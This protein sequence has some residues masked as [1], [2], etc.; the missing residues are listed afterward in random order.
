MQRYL[1]LLR[2]HP[3]FTRLWFAQI[4]SLAGDW[5][6]TVALSAL[7]IKYS[8]PE[9]QGLAI[10]LFFLSRAV[11]PMLLSP[12][13]GVLVDRFN[14]RWLMIGSNLLRFVV[15][16]G[17][18][19]V[20]A[21]PELL[22]AVYVLTIIQF[23]LTTVFEP[24][25]SAIMPALVGVDD[26]VEANTLMSA[27]WSAMLAFGAAVGGFVAATLGSPAALMID[28]LTFLLAAWLIWSIRGYH[29]LPHPVVSVHPPTHTL[30]DFAPI[31]ANPSATPSARPAAD[32][33]K[34]GFR[35]GLRYVLSH[36][37]VAVPLLGKSG[38]SIGN[39]DTLITIFATQ[40]FI[41]GADGQI[42]LG[43][44]YSSFGLGAILGPVILN[45]F[46]D[47]SVT[48]LR[49]LMILGFIA[50]AL[51][52]LVMGVAGSLL[53]ICLAL[54]IR[55]MGGSVNWTYSTVV[56]QKSADDAYLG[57]V[58]SLDMMGFYLA[59]VLSTLTHGALVDAVGAEQAGTVALGTFLVALVP[60]VVWVLLIRMLERRAAQLVVNEVDS[61]PSEAN[62][63]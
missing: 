36:P 11:P 30:E 51:G 32:H 52:W 37:E 28:A 1:R 55:A 40:V 27:T 35:D 61:Q 8:P 54:L 17:F 42:S 9:S 33:A 29:P 26:L 14:R 49:R 24:A 6:N 22:W 46:H 44:M 19:V 60:L 53:A 5:F 57:R 31:A 20:V 25:L 4:V 23:I 48:Q 50:A 39:V 7:V 59:S 21:N 62:V 13:A 12:I 56:L 43:I 3:D 10:S 18:L 16:L 15:V 63:Q 41:L 45:R 58:F 34:T 38:S 47:R 2:A